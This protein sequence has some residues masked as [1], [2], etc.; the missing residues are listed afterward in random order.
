VDEELAARREPAR[1]PGQHVLVVA[2]VL[3]HLHRE[4]PVEPPGGVEDL[5]VGGDDRDVAEAAGAGPP[6]D[7][8]PLVAAVRDGRDG[9][10][11]RAWL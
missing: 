9:G 2:Q 6:L 11:A 4:D 1:H 3:E 5:G 10:A 8:A 7:E